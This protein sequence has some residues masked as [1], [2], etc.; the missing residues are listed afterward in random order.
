MKGCFVGGFILAMAQLMG[1]H[2]LGPG[3]QLLS[4]YVVLLIVL[5][6]RPQGIFGTV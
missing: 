3:Y 2:F 4:G 5:A 1:A 6:L